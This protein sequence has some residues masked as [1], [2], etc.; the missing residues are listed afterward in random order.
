MTLVRFPAGVV[1]GT[2]CG[3]ASALRPAHMRPGP[4]PPQATAAAPPASLAAASVAEPPPAP[5]G[6]GIPGSTDPAGG[7]DARPAAAGVL[8]NVEYLPVT[9]AGPA[10]GLGA[11]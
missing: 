5:T 3:P 7:L 2:R 1:G 4:P 11:A 9:S 6:P 10:T 8:R